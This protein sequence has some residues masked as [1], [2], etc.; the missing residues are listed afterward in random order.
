MKTKLLFTFPA[1]YSYLLLITRPR[2][3]VSKTQ[4]SRPSP[5]WHHTDGHTL[6]HFVGQLAD[7]AIYF[8]FFLFFFF[9]PGL[10]TGQR[11]CSWD[12]RKTAKGP[13]R[14][15][16][17]TL[18]EP[19]NCHVPLGLGWSEPFLKAQGAGCVKISRRCQRFALFHFS[20]LC[21]LCLRWRAGSPPGGHVQCRDNATECHHPF[22]TNQRLWAALEPQN[23]PNQTH[24]TFKKV[25]GCTMR[26][27][28]V[29]FLLWPQRNKMPK[30]F[31]QWPLDGIMF[32]RTAPAH[33]H[34]S[35]PISQHYSALFPQCHCA[36]DLKFIF[37]LKCKKKKVKP[38]GPDEGNISYWSVLFLVRDWTQMR[39][40]ENKQ[41]DAAEMN[42]TRFKTKKR[43]QI[44]HKNPWEKNRESRS[45]TILRRNYTE[46][47]QETKHKREKWTWEWLINYR[48]VDGLSSEFIYL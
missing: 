17:G 30:S 47:T 40:A 2:S 12:K 41:N 9:F 31:F 3:V 37:F 33:R 6:T 4:R 46:N 38:S 19:T 22:F 29:W 11:G 25:T 5:A 39:P 1:T 35:S 43:D 23:Y 28:N 21:F 7:T 26:G 18:E 10:C 14:E 20:Q 16:G 27:K 32:A 15:A 42:K 34:Q 36:R 8:P 48:L 44:K 45:E 13:W 24:L